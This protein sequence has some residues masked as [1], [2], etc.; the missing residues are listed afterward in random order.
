MGGIGAGRQGFRLVGDDHSRGNHVDA[1]AL[2]LMGLCGVFLVQ[3]RLYMI[4]VS[5]PT[6]IR[7][8]VVQLFLVNATDK[9]EAKRLTCIQPRV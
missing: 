5:Y 1:G 3:L 7:T 6:D 8:G 9:M 4:G 2:P